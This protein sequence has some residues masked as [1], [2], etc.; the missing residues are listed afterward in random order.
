M[1]QNF[2]NPLG[3]AF[4]AACRLER[5]ATDQS[6]EQ[7]AE[8]I[9]IKPSFYKLV[10]NGTNY[11]HTNKSPSI[12]QALDG[13]MCLDGVSKMLLAISHSE[14]SARSLL[15]AADSPSLEHYIQGFQSSISQL[16]RMDPDK[17]GRLLLPYQ[18]PEVAIALA[19]ANAKDAKMVLMQHE[20]TAQALAFLGAYDDFGQFENGLESS[21]L[22]AK[23]ERVPSMYLDVFSDLANRFINLPA[24]VGFEE[25][26][27]WD[28]ENVDLFQEWWCIIDL[29]ENIVS[30]TNLSRCHYDML[31][32]KHFKRARILFIEPAD[33]IALNAN[34]KAILRDLHERSALG[35]VLPEKRIINAKNKL[36]TFDR[37][38]LK[39]QLNALPDVPSEQIKQMQHEIVPEPYSAFWVFKMAD[40]SLVGFYAKVT[41]RDHPVPN[42]LSE[43]VSLDHKQTARKFDLLMQL[44]EKCKEERGVKQ[45]L[46]DA[47][48]Y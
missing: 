22:V 37:A 21:S 32:G 27:R 28:H 47:R 42:M 36:K 6:V 1:K 2:R 16:S 45:L 33:T 31:W 8:K 41:G 35:D 25:M 34:F 18:K 5:K 19:T 9:G 13:K 46:Y 17:L 14:S 48:A 29:V 43:G 10:E 40:N 44:W 20:L 12:V 3:L 24:R 30:E 15:S 38:I 23:L 26:W 11:L 7:F 4:G 39:A